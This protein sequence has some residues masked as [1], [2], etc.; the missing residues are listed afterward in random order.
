MAS[1]GDRAKVAFMTRA[2]SNDDPLRRVPKLCHDVS[3]ALAWRKSRSAE[4]AMREREETV[5]HFEEVA[6]KLREQGLVE[7][8]KRY[9]VHPRVRPAAFPYC[10]YFSLAV[11]FAGA[12]RNR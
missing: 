9:D 2:L 4:E 5:S 10:T 7:A 12:R 6:S 8:W 1:D 11:A 3:E